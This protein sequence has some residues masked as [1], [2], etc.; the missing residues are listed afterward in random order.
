MDVALSIKVYIHDNIRG[1]QNSK[2]EI[3]I[4]TFERMNCNQKAHKKA[5]KNLLNQKN[6][7]LFISYILTITTHNLKSDSYT[8][9][10]KLFNPS[11]CFP[12]LHL[13]PL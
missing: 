10:L 9:I 12:D 11:F 8:F 1:I 13:I 5:N 4:L 2:P 3:G 7:H 6:I